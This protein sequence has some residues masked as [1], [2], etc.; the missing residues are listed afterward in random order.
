MAARR[1]DAAMQKLS[2]KRKDV[3]GVNNK[4]ECVWIGKGG[5][6]SFRLRE[7]AGEKEVEKEQV[8]ERKTERE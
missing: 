8:R 1:L 5:E 4:E 3:G 7:N 2:R 6:D